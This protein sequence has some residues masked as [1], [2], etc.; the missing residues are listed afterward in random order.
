MGALEGRTRRDWCG[1][2]VE[3]VG[4]LWGMGLE[5][6]VRCGPSGGGGCEQHGCTE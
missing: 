3:R 4:R 1:G 5:A 6:E 2:Q